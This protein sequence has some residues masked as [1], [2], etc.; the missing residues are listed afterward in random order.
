MSYLFFVCRTVP[1]LTLSDFQCS[2]TLGSNNAWM[3]KVPLRCM[4]IRFWLVDHVLSDLEID[5]LHVSIQSQNI[6]G[7]SGRRRE[8]HHRTGAVQRLGVYLVVLH[9]FR[10]LWRHWHFLF[11]NLWMCLLL[12][13]S[14]SCQYYCFCILSSVLMLLHHRMK[15]KAS[16]GAARSKRWTKITAWLGKKHIII[17]YMILGVKYFIVIVIHSF[18]SCFFLLCFY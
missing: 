2:I 17:N 12:L 7:I 5:H 8:K 18:L 6:T 1:D 4:N 14:F 13:W 9:I 16:R 11:E 10:D 15:V 3:L